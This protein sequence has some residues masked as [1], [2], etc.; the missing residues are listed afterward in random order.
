ME[1]CLYIISFDALN[2]TVLIQT[3][4]YQEIIQ[5]N[6]EV[7]K[8]PS[9]Q[10]CN[11]CPIQEVI[12]HTSNNCFAL[13]FLHVSNTQGR[14][15]GFSISSTRTS[16]ISSTQGIGLGREWLRYLTASLTYTNDTS[17]FRVIMHLFKLYSYSVQLR[18]GGQLQLQ[19]FT[20]FFSGL[21]SFFL[22]WHK[23]MLK[24]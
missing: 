7:H 16:S 9:Y 3:M 1:L 11:D 10:F 5:I 13:K 12:W 14:N 2:H 15:L 21:F 18:K 20:V 6:V 23:K 4:K 17:S 24:F 19:T 22:L 8:F